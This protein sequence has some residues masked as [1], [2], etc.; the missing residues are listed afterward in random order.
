[1]KDPSSRLL[2]FRLALEEYNFT[3]EYMK[4]K[5]NAAA[6]ALSRIRLSSDELKNM[7][8]NVVNVMTRAQ[9][10]KLKN[11]D[12]PIFT[13]STDD[14]VSTD[15]W[16][17]PPRVV[18]ISTQPKECVELSFINQDKLNTLIKECKIKQ[19]SAQNILLYV[20]SKK[21]IYINPSSHS[22]FT[23]AVF[24][25]ELEE[26]CKKCNIEAIY[27]IK[28][29]ETK[30]FIETL[31]KEIKENDTWTGPRLYIL[32]GIKRIDNK[33]DQKVILND[34]HLLPTSGHAGIRRMFNKIK[35]YYYWS[36]LERDIKDFISRCDKCQR[37]KHSLY[38]YM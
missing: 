4:G 27:C 36:G 21:A 24:V 2:K 10:R 3:V 25:R 18:E 16:K 19:S 28:N 9:A 26:F 29:N 7:Q 20:P 6:D 35:K 37:Q 14:I 17:D 12:T 32:Q 38:T 5:D 30:L 31:A 33:D 8:E 1:M 11:K 23:R 22:Q 34:F 13:S 15:H